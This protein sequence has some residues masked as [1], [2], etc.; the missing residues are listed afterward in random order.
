MQMFFVIYGMHVRRNFVWQ[1]GRID[2]NYKHDNK[3]L[4]H[5]N[6]KSRIV[7]N[8]NSLM[9]SGSVKKKEKFPFILNGKVELNATNTD[10]YV[11]IGDEYQLLSRI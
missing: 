11:S 5:P 7:A 4:C 6:E 8:P 10:K 3:F 1:I 2:R 9:K